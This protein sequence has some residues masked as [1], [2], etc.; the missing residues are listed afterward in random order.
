M[1]LEALVTSTVHQHSALIAL[2]VSLSEFVRR[3]ERVILKLPE[4]AKS[5]Q[6][7]GG[8]HGVLCDQPFQNSASAITISSPLAC[9]REGSLYKVE[10][11]E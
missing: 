11:V 8:D 6:N 1:L 10:V 2:S 4:G 9:R 5:N 3:A 7:K